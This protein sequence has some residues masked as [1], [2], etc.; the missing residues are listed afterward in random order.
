MN[1]I[2]SREEIA[3]LFTHLNLMK[4]SIRKG[5]KKTYKSC[6]EEKYNDYL[7]VIDVLESLIKDQESEIENFDGTF[8]DEQFNMLHSFI[9]WYVVEL[10]KRENNKDKINHDVIKLMAILEGIQFKLNVLAAS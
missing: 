4:K 7:S 8:A 2:F 3:V 1:L 10:N 5:F 6:W 9:N